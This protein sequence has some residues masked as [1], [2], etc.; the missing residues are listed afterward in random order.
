MGKKLC[1]DHLWVRTPPCLISTGV[2]SSYLRHSKRDSDTCRC[3]VARL[4]VREFTPTF[5]HMLS[6]CAQAQLHCCFLQT[7]GWERQIRVFY[8]SE[9]TEYT[10]LH[11]C[12][13]IHE[14]VSQVGVVGDKLHAI[15]CQPVSSPHISMGKFNSN[16]T[17]STA[18]MKRT[19]SPRLC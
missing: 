14:D 12:L 2:F 13:I 4:R 16:K 3:L 11:L 1:S 7:F 15:W 8:C 9:N 18:A 6:L 19:K 5:S 10:C 17:R